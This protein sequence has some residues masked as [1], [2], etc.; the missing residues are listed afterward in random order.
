[1]PEASC[2]KCG[3]TE[4]LMYNSYLCSDCYYQILDE[5]RREEEATR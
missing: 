4:F 1:M 2:P 3:A 5:M